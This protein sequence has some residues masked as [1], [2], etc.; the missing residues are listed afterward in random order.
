LAWSPQHRTP[1]DDFG[2]PRFSSP[3]A[4]TSDVIPAQ[5]MLPVPGPPR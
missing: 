2:S 3:E 5:V 1:V 4:M